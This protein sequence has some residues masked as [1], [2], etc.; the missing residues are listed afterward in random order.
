MKLT[1]SPWAS[2][3]PTARSV[4]L[5]V[6]LHGPVSRTELAHT[7][8]L[9]TASLT[10]LTKP[11][12]DSGLL[13]EQVSEEIPVGGPGRPLTPLDI[14]PQLQHFIGIKLTGTHAYGVV[15]TLRCDILRES[16]CEISR[17]DPTAVADDLAA[18][19]NELAADQPIAAVGVALGGSVRDFSLV[20]FATFLRW[21]DVDLR[22]LLTERIGRPVIIS[23]DLD[24]L[25]EAEHWFG[26][27][28]DVHSFATLTIGAG[29]G[30]GVVVHDKLIT[31][32]DSGIGL[33]GHFPLDP[34]GPV[35]THGHHGCSDA[36]LSSESIRAQATLLLNK[37]V[38]YDEVLDLAQTGDPA[39][40]LVVNRSA[41]AFGTLIAAV[42]NIVQPQRILLTGEGINLARVGR[43]SLLQGVAEARQP[44][45]SALD[46]RI[47]DYEPNLWARG[48]A[49]VAI[50]R[51]ILDDLPGLG[52]QA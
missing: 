51:T 37:S 48:A 30:L 39:M 35:C 46:L 44:E 12:L 3:S 19:V 41:F 33:I 25:M 1:E 21:H 5:E 18:F 31:G 14:D 2:L 6:L 22:A 45:T 49:A 7:L 32:P 16:T 29:V 20:K 23:N 8:N 42:A 52:T 10:R 26:D 38:S 17:S 34:T 28:R 27:G 43:T 40:E 36:L 13:V 4:A 15:T 24:A 11:L 47:L 50:Q 9:S